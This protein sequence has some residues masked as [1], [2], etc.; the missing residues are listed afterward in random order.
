MPDLC[1]VIR[2][3]CVY[4]HGAVSVMSTPRMCSYIAM[5]AAEETTI[6]IRTVRGSAHDQGLL[7]YDT[8][9]SPSVVGPR[10]TRLEM[11]MMLVLLRCCPEQSPPY[12]NRL[13]PGLRR[14]TLELEQSSRDWVLVRRSTLY[15][16]GP[17]HASA[18]LRTHGNDYRRL[19]V[20]SSI[21]AMSFSYRCDE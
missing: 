7:G 2:G 18:G 4:R 21:T 1:R 16:T 14:R 8:H 3:F 17:A 12:V 15:T 9:P 5:R 11:S 10:R 19:Q 13:S 6:A 20:V